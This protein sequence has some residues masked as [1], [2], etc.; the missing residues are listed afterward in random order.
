[1]RPFYRVSLLTRQVGS[2]LRQDQSRIFKLISRAEA[3]KRTFASMKER[4]LEHETVAA[5]ELCGRVL[6]EDVTAPHDVPSRNRAAMDGYAVRSQDTV[7]ASTSSPVRLTITGKRFPAD[8]A[9]GKI[10]KAECVYTS[11]GAPL[12]SGSDAVAQVENTRLVG[13]AIEVVRPLAP[14][15][16]VSIKGE[17]V[18]QGETVFKRGHQVPPQGIGMLLGLGIRSVKVVRKPRA[19]IISVGD[20]L[21]DA[22]GETQHRVVN[23]HAY[24]VR[25]LLRQLG[26]EP[27]ILGVVPDNPELIK[28]RISEALPDS[29]IVITI[30]GSS[31]GTK[32]FVPDVVASLGKTVFHGILVTPGKVT[33]VGIIDG[34]PVIML[35]GY[36]MSALAGFY[37]F[38]VPLVNFLGSESTN[39]LPVVEAKLEKTA[40]AK[41]GLERFQ[42]LQ[43]SKRGNS[44]VATTVEGQLAGRLSLNKVNAYTIIPKGQV[45]KKGKHVAATLLSPSEFRR[46]QTET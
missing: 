1:M 37:F 18:K 2:A 42:L 13:S 28:A 45:L 9:G 4:R 6:A 25:E 10:A 39:W 23:D 34:K 8:R 41:H 26:A 16:N 22:Y 5:D 27:K 24:I 40:R 46:I 11:T 33:G 21:V 15:E 19:S 35:P 3:L 31:V 44:Y 30:A 7:G 32:D 43:L 20:E 38:V 17:D 14:H 29:D 12:P 36:L